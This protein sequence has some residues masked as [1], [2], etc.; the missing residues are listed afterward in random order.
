MKYTIVLNLWIIAFYSL[1][2][3]L[4]K[5][6]TIFIYNQSEI[7][8]TQKGETYIYKINFVSEKMYEK[9]LSLIMNELNNMFLQLVHINASFL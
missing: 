7:T 2:F 4:S 3:F 8:G 9:V 1:L 5:L 6:F